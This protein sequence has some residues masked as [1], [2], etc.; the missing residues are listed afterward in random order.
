MM[1]NLNEILKDLVESA[2][3]QRDLNHLYM[4]KFRWMDEREYED[5]NDYIENAKKNIKSFKIKK[6]QKSF[7]IFFDLNGIDLKLKLNAK[8]YR[9]TRA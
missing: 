9:L 3:F 8:T 5:F 2:E 7:A 6:M 4:L 1:K